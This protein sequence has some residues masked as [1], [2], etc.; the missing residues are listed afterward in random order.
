MKMD[1]LKMYLLLTMVIFQC[2]ASFQG[3]NLNLK[4]PTTCCYPRTSL[5]QVTAS[6]IRAPS[7]WRRFIWGKCRRPK[8]LPGW[9]RLYNWHTGST[10]LNSSA[11]K[12]VWKKSPLQVETN[13][14][15][16]N[17]PLDWYP[18]CSSLHFIR[19]KGLWNVRKRIHFYKTPWNG[20]FIWIFVWHI[21]PC[22]I[23]ISFFNKMVIWQD[24]L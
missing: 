22:F 24:M 9:I 20:F 19:T 4:L 16:D 15:A 12:Y 18:W 1:H 23:W 11:L 21:W 2:H 6:P 13:H 8:G 14:I 3:G 5:S 17:I 10:T 7:S